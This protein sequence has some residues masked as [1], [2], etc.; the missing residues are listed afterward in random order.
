MP[1]YEC[2]LIARQDISSSQVDALVEQ[3]G[4]VITEGG[5]SIAGQEYW[6]LKNL[7]YKINKNRKGHYV[8]LNIDSPPDA[9]KEMERQ[10]RLNEDMLRYLTLR[11][12]EFE[13]GPSVQ[14]R[15]KNTRERRDDR[16]GRGDRDDRRDSRPPRTEDKA[17][18]PAET[19]TKS[20]GDAS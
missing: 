18:A 7:A 16:P 17:D 5:G 20:E 12:D 6:G 2:V 19:E 14:M 3:F 11:V 1:L 13:D 8:Q 10:M 4:N 9:V 15:N